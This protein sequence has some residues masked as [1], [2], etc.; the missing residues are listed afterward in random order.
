MMVIILLFSWIPAILL[1]RHLSRPL[2][3]LEN[4]VHRLANKEWDEPLEVNRKDEIGRLG[5]SIEELRTQLIRQDKAEQSFLQNVSHELKTPVM[6]IRS[7]AQA[8]KDGIYPKGNLNNSI[9]IID[10][11]AE[12]LEKKI[13]NLL[14]LTK[15]DYM[16]NHNMDYDIFS[17]DSIIKDVVSR[18]DWNRK[19]I[20]WNLDLEALDIKGDMEQW[21]IVIENLVDNQ[22][23]YAKSQI[24]ITLDN[25]LLRIW[26]DGPHME[27]ELLENLFKEFN[28]GSKGEFGLGLSIVKKILDIHGSTMNVKNE[29]VGVS[30]TININRD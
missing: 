13:K 26:N 8:I 11:E 18:M 25:S 21:K 1:S 2:I 16:E 22:I 30:F 6:V 12:R 19:D 4:R 10:E 3:N 27:E 5:T 20:D 29:E 17:L 15:L 9:E 7:F 14:Y 24:S 28:K 23:R